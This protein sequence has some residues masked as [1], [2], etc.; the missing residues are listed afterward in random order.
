MNMK[1]CL[2]EKTNIHWLQDFIYF[3]G[4]LYAYYRLRWGPVAC[5]SGKM[6]V[7]RIEDQSE[8]S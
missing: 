3:Y 6:M 8:S 1:E 2:H 5:W 4:F 7:S